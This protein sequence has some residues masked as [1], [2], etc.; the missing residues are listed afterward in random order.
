MGVKV[1]LYAW[2]RLVWRAWARASTMAHVQPPFGE[3]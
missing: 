3:K 1:K 2:T